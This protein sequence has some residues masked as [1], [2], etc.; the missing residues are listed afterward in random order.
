MLPLLMT[1]REMEQALAVKNG[2]DEAPTVSARTPI[3]EL[4]GPIVEIQDEML[5]FVH[6]TV[7]ERVA[8][9]I[10]RAWKM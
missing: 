7:K 3:L 5:Q 9:F 8:V 1:V 6:F 4:C 10:L 2:I